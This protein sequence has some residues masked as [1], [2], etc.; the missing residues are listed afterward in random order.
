MEDDV[1]DVQEK[2]SELT[3]RVRGRGGGFKGVAAK[4]AVPLGAA[5]TSAAVNYAV[6]KLPKLLE[7]RV[8]PKLREQGDPRDLAADAM[9]RV[10]EVVESHA[11]VG[12]GATPRSD[13][14]RRPRRSESERERGR[15]DRAARRHERRTA[16]R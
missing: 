6:R 14:Q 9:K 8:L 3:E 16:A 13:G 4:A 5:L 7:E 12:G 1:K 15:A 2:A 10:R 11:P